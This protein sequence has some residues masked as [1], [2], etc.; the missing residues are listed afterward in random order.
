MARPRE[1]SNAAE[2]QKAYRER[3]KA[4]TQASELAQAL[5]NDVQ[6]RIVS[7]RNVMKELHAKGRVIT[8]DRWDDKTFA[9]WRASFDGNFGQ[10][11]P[12]IMNH[13]IRT[14]QVRFVRKAPIHGK[15][16]EFTWFDKED[17]S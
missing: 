15:I 2:K 14:N 12:L 16:Y 9:M 6:E 5:L 11:E 17:Q 4:N 1:F 8:I 10:I 3:L 7:L 13:L